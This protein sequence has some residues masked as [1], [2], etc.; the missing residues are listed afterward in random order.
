MKKTNGIATIFHTKHDQLKLLAGSSI[1]AELLSR[2][3][4]WWQIS[5]YKIKGSNHTWFT[6]KRI[7]IS[8]ETG[9]PIRSLDRYIKQLCE[10]G[11]IEKAVKERYVKMDSASRS[12]IHIRV[13]SKLL[14][15]LNASPKPLNNTKNT[16]GDIKTKNNDSSILKQIGNS[17]IANL[18]VSSINKGDYVN[19]PNIITKSDAVSFVN[20]KSPSITTL[21]IE[22]EFGESVTNELKTRVKGMLFNVLKQKGQTLHNQDR[23]FAE[24]IFSITNKE[25]FKH[26]KD[27]THKINAIAKVI[28]KGSWETPKGFYN[29]SHI[30]MVFKE[31]DALREKR[32]E[33]E[34]YE[35]ELEGVSCPKQ[36]AEI[37][38]RFSITKNYEKQFKSQSYQSSANS[39]HVYKNKLSSKLLEIENEIFSEGQ[40]LKSCEDNFAKGVG[41]VTQELIDSVIKK[42]TR[43]YDE[44]EK[45]EKEINQLAT[46]MKSCA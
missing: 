19:N 16:S 1:K 3:I 34:K 8:E 31:K 30:G 21:K 28:A 4:F 5:T 44:Q 25:Q 24:V 46:D 13:T 11:L 6:R 39:T 17:T 9:I 18:A 32:I 27:V 40:Y 35:R 38:Q 41:G 43:L 45:I 37:K 29:H 22:K 7:Q 42:L 33:R 20:K 36:I 23:L 10:K 26:C 14:K 12:V 15:L 2:F